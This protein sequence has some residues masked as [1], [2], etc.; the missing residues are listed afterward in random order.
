MEA[1][2]QED[3]QKLFDR[4]NRIEGQVR[5]IRKM[6]EEDRNCF[7]VLKQVAAA[8]G[9]LQ[10]MAKVIFQHHMS[11][12]IDHALADEKGRAELIGHLSDVFR[13]LSK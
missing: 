2:S 7:E 5:G 4:V 11:D 9:A 6:M 10:S 13:Q 1:N 12:C 3:K 8:A